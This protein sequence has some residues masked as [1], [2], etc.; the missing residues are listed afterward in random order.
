M[1]FADLMFPFVVCAFALVALVGGCDRARISILEDD[2]R[3][4]RK[5]INDLELRVYRIELKSGVA[6]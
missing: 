6:K 2:S 4:Y 1:S 3:Y 5:R